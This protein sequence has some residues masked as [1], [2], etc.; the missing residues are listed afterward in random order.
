[1]VYIV[2]TKIYATHFHTWETFECE[3]PDKPGLV[4]I[5]GKASTGKTSI[6]KIVRWCIL[7]EKA[8]DINPN[9][10]WTKDWNNTIVKLN[11]TQHISDT[12]SR[13]IELIRKK[14]KKSTSSVLTIQIDNEPTIVDEI[15]VNNELEALTNLNL[16]SSVSDYYGVQDKK[17]WFSGGKLQ[18]SVFDDLENEVNFESW[19]DIT[20]LNVLTNRLAAMFKTFDTKIKNSPSW[21]TEDKNKLEENEN[22]RDHHKGLI[23]SAKTNLSDWENKFTNFKAENPE[24][25]ELENKDNNYA[26]V[27]GKNTD[28]NTAINNSKKSPAELIEYLNSAVCLAVKNLKIGDKIPNKPPKEVIKALTNIQSWSKFE[29]LNSTDKK[30]IIESSKD[31]GL[32]C[33]NKK[34]VSLKSPNFSHIND[35]T[36]SINTIHENITFLHDLKKEMN[37]AKK[38]SELSKIKYNLLIEK[39]T[40]TES[41]PKYEHYKG[42]CNEL[43]NKQLAAEGKDEVGRKRTAVSELESIL[44]KSMTS[45]LGNL[46]QDRVE[47]AN[48]ILSKMGSEMQ[49]EIKFNPENGKNQLFRKSNSDFEAVINSSSDDINPGHKGVL[50]SALVAAELENLSITVPPIW[51][52]SI[53]PSDGDQIDEVIIGLQNWTQETQRQAFII[54]N[55]PELMKSSKIVTRVI[56]CLT[57]ASDVRK[58]N[59]ENWRYIDGD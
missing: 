17:W 13:E 27:L 45:V 42:V 44:T 28:A 51:D 58:R 20:G 54:S 8:T 15:A 50:F 59:N 35:F 19:K 46:A 41:T 36:N 3:L 49:I 11:I 48:R 14:N 24:W 5:G 1:M 29:Q 7:G 31:K 25:K 55:R 26:E 23:E 34:G 32:S 56:E 57:V 37:S 53:A 16:K 12:Q 9:P 52:D 18:S 39:N 43:L 21:K 10:G 30:L 4:L 6:M 2:V 22:L 40:I 47:S 38:I 33:Q